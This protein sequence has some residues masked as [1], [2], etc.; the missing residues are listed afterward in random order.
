MSSHVPDLPLHIWQTH[1]F[2][3]ACIDTRL[4]FGVPPRKAMNEETALY[5][6]KFLRRRARRVKHSEASGLTWEKI[7][8]PCTGKV[9]VYRAHGG[10]RG[11]DLVDYWSHQVPS[12]VTLWDYDSA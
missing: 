1:I 6:D 10:C 8:I 9:L 12:T 7:R 4:A 2:P 11:C 5:L 3:H